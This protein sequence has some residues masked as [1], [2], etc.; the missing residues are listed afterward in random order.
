MSAGTS[1]AYLNIEALKNRR[2]LPKRNM[3]IIVTDANSRVTLAV[4]RALKGEHIIALESDDVEYSEVLGFSSRFVKEKLLVPSIRRNPELYIKAIIE[5]AQKADVVLPI[6]TNS[7]LLVAK[8]FHMMSGKYLCPSYDQLIQANDKMNL[9]KVA[10]KCNVPTPRIFDC[11]N[12][13][14]VKR[15]C[16]NLPYPLV[17]KL[18]SDEG[19]Y[20]QPGER[21]CI[22][23]APLELLAAYAKLEKI[24]PHP[25]IQEFVD[26]D[27]YG[28]S[29]LF[30]HNSRP[31]AYFCHKRLREYPVSGGPST[32]CQSVKEDKLIEHGMALLSFLKWKGIAMVE[33]RKDKESGQFKL[34]EIN[35]RFWGTLPLAIEAGINFPGILCN[36][37]VGK[38][39][40]NKYGYKEGVRI[41]FLFLDMLAFLGYLKKCRNKIWFSIKF[42]LSFF[43]FKTKDGML[44]WQD[45]LPGILCFWTS[46]KKMFIKR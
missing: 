32:Y 18:R 27:G 36:L 30:D 4:I 22:V 16:E 28:F 38:E 21:Y 44:S 31:R 26:G 3:N 41:R 39:V 42:F 13:E 24:K 1:V 29:G 5:L 43:D 2:G 23:R 15:Q 20:L 11:A 34:M 7:V 19:L 17:V 46:I 6:A 9:M 14:Q 35:P 33:F 40:Q 25:L 10:R 45:P 12:L 8:N 37:V